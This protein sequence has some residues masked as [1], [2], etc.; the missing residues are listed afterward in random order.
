MNMKSIMVIAGI[1]VVLW[2]VV[3]V[4]IRVFG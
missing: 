4:V 2:A 1:S 3:V